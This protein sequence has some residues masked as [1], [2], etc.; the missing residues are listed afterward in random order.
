MEDKINAFIDETIEQKMFEFI[1]DVFIGIEKKVFSMS[2]EKPEIKDKLTNKEGML[3]GMNLLEFYLNQVYKQ[4]VEKTDELI[5]NK[6]EEFG[7]SLKLHPVY[8]LNVITN[9]IMRIYPLFTRSKLVL[10]DELKYIES[11]KGVTKTM[12]KYI[13]CSLNDEFQKL[14]TK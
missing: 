3:L 7:T 13:S 6:F 8:T 11:V 2:V 12:R 9:L 10:D 1:E 4:L 5:T 14:I